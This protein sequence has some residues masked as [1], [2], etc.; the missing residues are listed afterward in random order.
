[1]HPIKHHVKLNLVIMYLSSQRK[2][3]IQLNMIFTFAHQDFHSFYNMI[4]ICLFLLTCL[5]NH[6]IILVSNSF[7]FCSILNSQ[8][9]TPKLISATPEVLK[10]IGMKENYLKSST[11]LK[12]LSGNVDVMSMPLPNTIAMPPSSTSSTSCITTNNRLTMLSW[13]SPYAL[14]IYGEEMYSNCPFRNGNGYGDGR[15]IS[16]AEVV[17]PSSSERYE[18][19]LKGAGTTPFCRGGD[20]CAVLRSSVREY[21]ASEAM[22]HLGMHA[23]MR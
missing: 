15:A 20:G 18:L 3:L 10:L 5:V 7:Y 4:Y 6:T 16:I 9:P 12:F 22:H 23:W 13:A 8:L 17:N 1:M 11:F 14:S 19:Q 21:L 2:I